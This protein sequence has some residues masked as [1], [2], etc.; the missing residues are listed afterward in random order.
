[1]WVPQKQRCVAISSYEAEF[2]AATTAAC[3][4]IWLWNLLM[5]ITD[6]EPCPVA[7]YVDNKSAI[8]LTKNPVFHHRSKHIDIMVKHMYAQT[9]SG[10]SER[11]C[12]R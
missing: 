11:P 12:P 9:S 4:G 2:M 6:V 8:D 10:C 3:Q 7:I 5:Q 1:M